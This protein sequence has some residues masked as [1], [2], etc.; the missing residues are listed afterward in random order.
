MKHAGHPL[1]N[2][3]SYGGN[4]ILKGTV[5][6]KYRQ[7]VENAFELCRRQALHAASLG[8]IHPSTKEFRHFEAELPEDMSKVISKWRDYS[9]VDHTM[10]IGRK[11]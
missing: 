7:F 9:N 8:F 5:F 2:D 4:Q 11:G 6:S 3:E 10:Q 1:F